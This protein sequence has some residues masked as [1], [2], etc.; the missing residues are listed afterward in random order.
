VSTKRLP[1]NVLPIWTPR[2]SVD[3]AQA[4]AL[5]LDNAER[6]VQDYLPPVVLFTAR[7]RERKARLYDRLAV[8]LLL[9]L[10]AALGVIGFTLAVPHAKAD[11]DNVVVAY[12]AH[13]GG[14]V[15]S[16]LDEFP[17]ENGILGIGKSIIEDGLT[18]YQAGQ[19]LYLSVSDVCPRHMG[20]LRAF[21][22]SPEMTA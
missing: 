14:A 10:C 9:L 7:S 2:D 21:A 6:G 1:D 4:F 18:G 11:V 19:V 20:L 16:V 13:Y 15:C 22:A 3:T 5:E 8:A 17:S 12:S